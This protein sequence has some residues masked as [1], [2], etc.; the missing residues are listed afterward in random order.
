MHDCIKYVLKKGKNRKR[1]EK[2]REKRKN[3]EKSKKEK[4]QKCTIHRQSPFTTPMGSQLAHLIPVIYQTHTSAS[5]LV[6][7]IPKL[8]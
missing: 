8:N 2:P 3:T 7:M 4:T 5:F 6:H 1:K